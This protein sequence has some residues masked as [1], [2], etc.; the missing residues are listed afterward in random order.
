[1]GVP[2]SFTATATGFPAPTFGETGTLPAGVTFSSAG[3]L[4]G[5]P[6]PGTA[7]SYP[8]TITATNGVSPV[9]NQAFTL[10][11]APMGI[12]TT[13]L[14]NGSVYTM[15]LKNSYKVTLA[16]A[17]GNPPYKWSLAPGSAV[18]PTGLKLSSK[19]VISGK[20]SVAGTFHF[21]V[22]VV[23]KKTKTKPQTQNT[24]TANLSITIS[25]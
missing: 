8:I 19:G 9:A 23:D 2:G 13:S 18:L 4:S 10:H 11:V 16:A 14:P 3:V 20:A 15:T 7:G 25:P 24:V 6:A 21:T 12:T 22:Q 1:M 5:T 17:G